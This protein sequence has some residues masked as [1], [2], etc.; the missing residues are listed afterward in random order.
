MT[1]ACAHPPA[2]IQTLAADAQPPTQEK[3]KKWSSAEFAAVA[4]AY[5]WCASQLFVCAELH[6]RCLSVVG[7][8]DSTAVLE[9]SL[10]QIVTM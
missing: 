6:G 7:E 8:Y 2:Y 4:D 3:N 9:I 5:A 1:H 10:S